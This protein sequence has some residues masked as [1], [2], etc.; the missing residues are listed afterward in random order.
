MNHQ[1]TNTTINV[2]NIL[3][4]VRLL[5]TPLFVILLLRRQLHPAL[6]VFVL[7]GVSDGLDGLIAR[8]FDQ[9]TILGAYLDPIADK[10][11][12]VSA[13]VCLA[14]LGLVP[15]W[16]TVIVISRDVLIVIGIVIFTLTQKSYRIRPSMV[17]KC[18]TT[19][20]ILTVIAALLAADIPSFAP[21]LTGLVWSVALLT[22]VSGLHYIYLGMTIL[23]AADEKDVNP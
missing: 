19:V 14:I 9:R 10:V 17:S 1:R 21:I 6:L 3:T 16:L 2:P 5:L 23:Q 20:Q 8:C 15:D 13:F 12:L 18:T 4:L 22:T 7:A 11:L